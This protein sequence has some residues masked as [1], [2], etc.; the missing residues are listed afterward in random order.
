M[1]YTLTADIGDMSRVEAAALVRAIIKAHGITFVEGV[2]DEGSPVASRPSRIFTLTATLPDRMQRLIGRASTL[3]EAE[4]MLQRAGA[5]G[6]FRQTGKKE[7][8]FL[9]LGKTLYLASAG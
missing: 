6:E 1:T 9:P 4:M 2:M 5:T 8:A 7:W 3:H